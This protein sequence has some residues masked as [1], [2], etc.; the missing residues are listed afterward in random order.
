MATIDQYKIKLTV[1]GQQAV[2]T[3]RNSVSGLGSALAGIGFAAFIS[4]ALK[5]ADAMD[6]I[7]KATGLSIGYVT[8]LSQSIEQAGGNFD[9]AGKIITTFFNT[10]DQA[11]QGSDKAQDALAKVGIQLSDLSRLSEQQLLQKA[12]DNLS[13]MDAGAKRT[14]LAVDVFGKAIKN[15]D[16]TTLEEALDSKDVTK[17]QSE[18]KKAADV[19]DNLQASFRE[20]QMAAIGILTPF[21]GEVNNFKLSAKQAETVVKTLG[22]ALGI[23]FSVKIISTIAEIVTIIKALN[24]ALKGTVVVQT[25]LLALQGPKGWAII[26][27]GAT[28]AAGAVYALNKALEET[29]DTPTTPGVVTPGVVTP[30]KAAY[31]ASQVSK[32]TKEE[33]QARKTALESAKQMTEQLKRQNV[34][35]EYYQQAINDTVGLMDDEADRIRTNA[36]LEQDAA[37]KIID[38][39][40]QIEIEK[41]KGRGT[42]QAVID[43]LIKQKDEIN[44]HLII[45]K[46]LKQEEANRLSILE[47]Q[48]N[49]IRN[50]GASIQEQSELSK[51]FS[52]QKLNQNVI[53]GKITQEQM[54]RLTELNNLEVDYSKRT[55]ALSA[56]RLL[57]T[58]QAERESIDQQLKFAKE[59]YDTQVFL[60]KTKFD[61]EDELRQSSV[62]GYRAAYEAIAQSMTPY[63]VAQ[64]SVNAIWSSMSTAI[65]NFVDHG[66][67]SFSDF[68]NSIIKDL[69]K[70]E[71][72]AAAVNLYKMMSGMGGGGGG[73]G[74]GSFWSTALSFLGF[75]NGGSPPV[76]KPSIVGE[77]GPE[78]FVPKTSGTIV[79]NSALGGQSGTYITNNINALDAK[80][81]AQLFT[82]N[83]RLLLGSVKAAEKELPYRGR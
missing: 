34:Q 13:K 38:L 47:K 21:I 42:N 48:R 78:L 77:Q 59:A 2:D 75:A 17:L 19:V 6:D 7:A 32:Y 39:T 5:M 4:S 27:A 23:A 29:P 68:A 25:S 16:P 46:A 20:L 83:R 66:K 54:A 56:Q 49:T 1:E 57:S 70:I 44:N 81:V 51:Q 73:G 71:L 8:A 61:Q 3:L 72:K 64:N 33:V 41:S 62:A 82:E 79:P 52:Q 9:D 43:E 58:T 31:E 60:T 65:D 40:K 67:F 15:V 24:T 53:D 12:I 30:G 11:A 37:N 74:G 45:T 63:M 35:A 80:S 28:A 26:A 55:E 10:L 36:S 76:G 14:A 69:V 50:I 18:M 22:I